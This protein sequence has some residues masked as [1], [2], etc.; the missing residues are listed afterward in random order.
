MVVVAAENLMGPPK[1][2]H[3]AKRRRLDELANVLLEASNLNRSTKIVPY[4]RHNKT[5]IRR[6]ARRES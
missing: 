1:H 2:H 4:A 3:E 6:D 5:R